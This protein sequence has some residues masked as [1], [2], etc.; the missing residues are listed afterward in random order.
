MD[1]ITQAVLGGAVGEAVLG[2]R[3]GAKA[4]AWGAALG[5]LPDLDVVVNPFVSE[6][7][8][9]YIHRGITHGLLFGL[10][11]G[12][13]AGRALARLHRRDGVPWTRWALLAT[14]AL[15]THPMLDSLTVYGTQLFRPFT[16]Y[17]VI[18]AAVSIIDPLYTGPLLAG[19]VV[20]LR[21][22][23]GRRRAWANGLGLAVS[24]LYLGWA[25]GAKA[26]ASARFEAALA[27][28]GHRYDR[29]LTAPTLATTFLWTGLATD[30]TG[31]W[32]G[33]YS[34]FDDVPIRFERVPKRPELLA[35]Y[36]DAL[37]VERLFW[38]SRGYYSAEARADTL[39][40]H[41]L[42]FGRLDVWLTEDAPYVFTF[43]LRRGPAGK[44]TGFEQLAP[45]VDGA[46]WERYWERIW[47]R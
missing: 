42:R 44:V 37:P 25:L 23:P 1:S 7:A 47:G 8:A 40:V 32:V 6:V 5:T 16:D 13:L 19:L 2:R 22:S 4:A 34:V 43:R 26:H 36:A 33:L 30:A 12:P 18:L 10:V 11:L 14:L 38:F 20:A 27:D 17:P 28:A 39:L 45:A 31:T 15:V 41:D 46:P 9:L 3:V 35:P 24:T 21:L 29:L